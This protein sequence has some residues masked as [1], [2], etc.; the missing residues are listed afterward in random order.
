MP[1]ADPI[2]ASV[3]LAALAHQAVRDQARDQALLLAVTA[4]CA[5][6]LYATTPGD[7]DALA[8]IDTLLGE[9][10]DRLVAPSRG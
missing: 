2:D 7:P 1:D 8:R 6:L 10:L 3:R 5:A 9:T 4:E